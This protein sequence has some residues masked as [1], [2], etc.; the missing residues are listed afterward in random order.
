MTP[1]AQRRCFMISFKIRAF[2][3]YVNRDEDLK[4]IAGVYSFIINNQ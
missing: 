2:L 3:D 1:I 4:L